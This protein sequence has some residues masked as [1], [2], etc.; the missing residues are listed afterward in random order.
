MK[1]MKEMKESITLLELL[2]KDFCEFNLLKK[3]KIFII[4]SPSRTDRLMAEVEEFYISEIPY[5]L[6]IKKV[7]KAYHYENAVEVFE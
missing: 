6:L 7:F 5:R 4:K 3:I 1:E 2:D